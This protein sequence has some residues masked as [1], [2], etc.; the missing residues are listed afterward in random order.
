MS[1]VM[2]FMSQR[3]DE[4]EFSAWA[5]HATHFTVPWTLPRSLRD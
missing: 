4:N 1:A 3:L 5:K 2:L